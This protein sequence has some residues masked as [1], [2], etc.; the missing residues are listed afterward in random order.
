MIKFKSK[1]KNDMDRD[2]EIIIFD[3]TMMILHGI[4]SKLHSL[5]KSPSNLVGISIL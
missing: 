4:D 5:S 3:Y 2:G 1:T